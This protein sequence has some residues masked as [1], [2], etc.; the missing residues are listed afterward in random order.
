MEEDEWFYDMSGDIMREI[1]DDEDD[2]D[3]EDIDT[4]DDDDDF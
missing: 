1:E 2:W 4:W 3:D